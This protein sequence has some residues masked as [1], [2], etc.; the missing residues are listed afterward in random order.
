MVK[1]WSWKKSKLLILNYST[2]IRV[3]SSVNSWTHEGDEL[4]AS[5][6]N[7]EAAHLALISLLPETPEH[8]VKSFELMFKMSLVV[9]WLKIREMN[10]IFPRDKSHTEQINDLKDNDFS[11]SRVLWLDWWRLVSSKWW[12]P[13]KHGF[14][15]KKG[16][17]RLKIN[18][19]RWQKQPTKW[20][21][22]SVHRRQVVWRSAWWTCDHESVWMT[23][24]WVL[25]LSS[26]GAEEEEE[27]EAWWEAIVETGD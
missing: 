12:R 16:E 14:N 2:H 22:Y 27:W 20:N 6:V 17:G 3:C 9:S 10:Q 24:V 26:T 15:N 1:S 23:W 19:I 7:H 21:L 5:L 11:L 4:V 25:Q 18:Q 13:E 8:R